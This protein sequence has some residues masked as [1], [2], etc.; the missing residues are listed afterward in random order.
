[1]IKHSGMTVLQS[2][3]L[4][5]L[6]A[7]S[8]HAGDLDPVFVGSWP[9]HIRGPAASVAVQGNYAYLA[10]GL[11]GFVVIDISNP[12]KPIQVGHYNTVGRALSLKVLGQH[13][14]V[15]DQHGGLQI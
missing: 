9:G 7:I 3:A 12:Q 4:V 5:W 11:A 13:C 10:L 15:A 6:L 2:A 8:T 1:M 14:Y